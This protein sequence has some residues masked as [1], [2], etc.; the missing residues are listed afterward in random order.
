[1]IYELGQAL[2]RPVFAGLYRWRVEGRE[3]VPP[4]GPLIVAANHKSYMDPPLLGCAVRRPLHYMAKAEL[5]RIPL[6]GPI[7][8]RIYAF[9]VQRGAA[10]RQAIRTALDILKAGGAVA[11]FPEGRRSRTEALLPPQRGVGLLALK[12]GAP[13]VPAAL[14]GTGRVWPEGRKL[15]GLPRLAVRFGPPISFADLEAAGRDATALAGERIMA[16]IAALH[17]S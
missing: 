16:A 17:T 4:A 10:D 1:M 15:P 8:P 5:F 3:H 9:P 12:G 13:V 6:L 7:L 14:L 11:L 2:L